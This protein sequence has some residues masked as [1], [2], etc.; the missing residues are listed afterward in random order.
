MEIKCTK[1]FYYDKSGIPCKIKLTQKLLGDDL[2]R[3]LHF[4]EET[5]KW[6]E[7]NKQ[8]TFSTYFLDEVQ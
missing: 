4:C 5:M 8:F 2:D 7:E 3:G 6:C 1:H